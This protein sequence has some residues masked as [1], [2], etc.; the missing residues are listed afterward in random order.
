[1]ERK[2]KVGSTGCDHLYCF[3]LLSFSPRRTCLHAKLLQLGPTLCDPTDCSLLGSSVCGILQARILEWVVMLSSRG[4]FPPKDGTCRLCL[5]HWQM[6]SLPL[7]PP[8]KPFLPEALYNFWRSSGLIV[9]NWNPHLDSRERRLQ[10][11]MLLVTQSTW[12]PCF[13]KTREPRFRLM[14]KYS[15]APPGTLGKV[16][17][18]W[19]NRVVSKTGG[20]FWGIQER[21][22]RVTPK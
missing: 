15:E 4:S 9:V 3:L 7:V 5:L 10:A 6:G 8:G 22:L 19:R 21:I 14:S 2:P 20:S 13:N 16:S 1:M 18:Q 11:W 17:A 12:P